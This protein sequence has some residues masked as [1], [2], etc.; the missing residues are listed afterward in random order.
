MM[1]VKVT[2]CAFKA[3]TIFHASCLNRITHLKGLYRPFNCGEEGR[4]AL[5]CCARILIFSSFIEILKNT[6]QEHRG[7]QAFA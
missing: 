4:E 6:S 7:D 5:V 3:E 1:K 2:V